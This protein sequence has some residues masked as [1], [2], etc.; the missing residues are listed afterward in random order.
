MGG[1]PDLAPRELEPGGTMTIRFKLTMVFIAVILVANSVLSFVS[2]EYLGGVWLD[3]VQ[4]RVRRN[5]N[6]ARAAY[7]D[8]IDRLLYF[9][10]AVSVDR[11]LAAAMENR[12]QAGLRS[13]L[14]DVHRA[15]GMDFVCVLD[16]G[17]KVT[18]RAWDPDRKG[19]D[20]SRNPVVAK[21]LKARTLNKP[22]PASGTIILSARVWPG[23]GAIC[24][25][26]LISSSSTPW[27]RGPPRSSPD[28]TG[29]SS[30]RRFPSWTP[31]G[32]WWESCT[33]AIC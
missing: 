8:R 25:S 26:G 18:C 16:P 11:T 24:R 23:K 27:R 4:T 14:R 31:G 32:A 6:S 12:D 33:Q 10:R 28:P 2:V 3:E 22:E 7:N 19:D 17:G 13:L 1:H 29:W 9:L 30:P 20:L 5:L 21:V 15:G